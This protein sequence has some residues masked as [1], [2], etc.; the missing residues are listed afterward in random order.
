MK[1]ERERKKE[2]EREREKEK[3]FKKIT[4]LFKKI[5]KLII[6]FIPLYGSQIK[7]NSHGRQDS[8]SS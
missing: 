8:P 2:R 5:K 1:R 3:E 7:K 6:L 4:I